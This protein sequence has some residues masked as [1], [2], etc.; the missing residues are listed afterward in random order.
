MKQS[1][2]VDKI[3]SMINSHEE[4]NLTETQ[5]RQLTIQFLHRLTIIS[6]IVN[7]IEIK[8]HFNNPDTGKVCQ[9]QV[10]IFIEEKGTFLRCEK[11]PYDHYNQLS[12]TWP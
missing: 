7:T 11:F 4:I 2:L 12:S 6:K 9:A 5:L 10:N 3:S 8:C 1:E